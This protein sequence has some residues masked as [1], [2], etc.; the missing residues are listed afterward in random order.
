MGEGFEEQTEVPGSAEEL[1]VWKSRA[2]LVLMCSGSSWDLPMPSSYFE[3][4]NVC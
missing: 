4:G 3:S 2:R 1:G